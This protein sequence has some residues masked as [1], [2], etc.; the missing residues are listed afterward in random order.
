[1]PYDRSSQQFDE[2]V[3]EALSKKEIQQ[4]A[5]QAGLESEFLRHELANKTAK[6]WAAA[7]SEIETFNQLENAFREARRA[8]SAL[9]DDAMPSQSQSTTERRGFRWGTAIAGIIGAIGTIIGA[10]A[11]LTASLT[12]SL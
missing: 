7:A 4:G 12:A 9:Q 10:L 6:V 8:L 5:S 2:L 11:S 1:M 3:D